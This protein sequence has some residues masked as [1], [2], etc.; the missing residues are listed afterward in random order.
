MI[1]KE[2][3]ADLSDIANP[4]KSKKKTVKFKVSSGYKQTGHMLLTRNI[5]EM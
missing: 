2:S 5:V 1:F 3:Y 4:V